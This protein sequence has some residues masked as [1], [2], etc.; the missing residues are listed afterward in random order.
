MT[1]TAKLTLAGPIAGASSVSVSGNTIVVGVGEM[2]N[3]GVPPGAAYVFVRPA[4]GWTNTAQANAELTASNPTSES[5]LGY[6]V[7]ISGNTIVAGAPDIYAN[8]PGAAYVFVEPSTGW[9]NSTE[10]AILSP[11]DGIVN[12]YFRLRGF[13]R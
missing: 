6:S 2:G 12:E 13:Y 10:T 4:Q 3:G 1:E 5:Y 7:S 11:L 8:A 9:A